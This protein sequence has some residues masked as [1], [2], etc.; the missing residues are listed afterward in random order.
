MGVG[1]GGA[2]PPV[3]VPEALNTVLVLG[4]GR[5]VDDVL[6]HQLVEDVEIVVIVDLIYQSADDGLDLFRQYGSFPSRRFPAMVA[7]WWERI[8]FY[9]CA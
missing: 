8:R 9:M 1:E 2:N 7:R 6:R 4:D 5:V 3:D